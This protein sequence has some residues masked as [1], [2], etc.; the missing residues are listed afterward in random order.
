ML[1]V[2]IDVWN[3][4]LTVDLLQSSLDGSTIIYYHVNFYL[5]ILIWSKHTNLIK[6]DGVELGVQFV[7][8]LL[9]RIAIWAIG[10]A[11]YRYVM[12][13]GIC[14]TKG[15]S[16]YVPTGYSSMMLCALVF[17]ADMAAG[18]TE[19]QVKNR[20][21]NEMVGNCMRVVFGKRGYYFLEETT[22]FYSIC[23]KGMFE[24]K[25][26]AITDWA[27]RLCIRSVRAMTCD[28]G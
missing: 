1:L 25:R 15:S 5:S 13:L 18:L 11:E 8:Q 27:C 4:G 2:D 3:G 23:L 9:S 19:V 22:A 6:L 28:P 24:W 20:R 21:R 26:I 16:G 17:A 12:M 10:L 14:R 7:Q